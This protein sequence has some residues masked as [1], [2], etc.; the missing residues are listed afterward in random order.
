MSVEQSVQGVASGN[1]LVQNPEE[2]GS[3]I[4]PDAGIPGR[5]KP[6]LSPAPTPVLLSSFILVQFMD[7]YFFIFEFMC[8]A[9]GTESFLIL[10]FALFKDSLIARQHIESLVNIGWDILDYCW[11]MI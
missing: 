4:C 11:G 2:F 9:T 10:L 7:V 6:E 5:V 3:D 1:I 8:V